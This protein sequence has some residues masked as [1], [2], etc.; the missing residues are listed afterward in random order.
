MEFVSVKLRKISG[1]QKNLIQK[2][3]REIDSYVLL[4][5]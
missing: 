5:L 1:F 2:E 3:K 4:N